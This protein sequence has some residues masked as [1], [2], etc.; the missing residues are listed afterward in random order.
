MLNKMLKEQRIKKG[1]SQAEAA[2]KLGYE[3][4]QFIS[5]ME[6]GLS[7]VPMSALRKISKTYGLSIVRLKSAYMSEVVAKTAKE[8][9][10]I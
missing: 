7:K 2:R 4:P 3:T 8:L 10:K 9:S 6:R 1:F 5:I